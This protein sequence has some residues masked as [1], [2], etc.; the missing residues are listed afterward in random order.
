MFLLKGNSSGIKL[1]EHRFYSPWSEKGREGLVTVGSK[2]KHTFS[3]YWKKHS[4]SQWFSDLSHSPMSTVCSI[5]LFCQS[6]Q[7]KL[8]AFSF[9]SHWFISV[10]PHA[11]RLFFGVCL[12]GQR[13][14]KLTTANSA[15]RFSQQWRETEF[16][17]MCFVLDAGH[18][19]NGAF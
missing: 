5:Q 8:L 6:G 13:F 16:P 12:R 17:W 3:F 10:N 1:A 18:L 11:V 14:I 9:M 2:L 19:V 4:K 15:C 7:W